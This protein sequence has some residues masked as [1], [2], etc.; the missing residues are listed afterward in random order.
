MRTACVH[1]RVTD[2]PLLQ[3]Y[4]A[5]SVD[6]NDVLWFTAKRNDSFVVSNADEDGTSMPCA[7]TLEPYCDCKCVRVYSIIRWFAP[8]DKGLPKHAR[9]TP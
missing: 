7:S 5:V 9:S 4:E 1:A 3:L 6:G 2:G 8:A